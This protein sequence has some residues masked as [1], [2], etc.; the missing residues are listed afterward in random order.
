MRNKET[1]ENP[2]SLWVCVGLGETIKDIKT[3]QRTR[4]LPEIP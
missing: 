1:R 3:M 2:V 4:V